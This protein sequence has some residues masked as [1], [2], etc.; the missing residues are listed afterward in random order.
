LGQAVSGV[1]DPA[2]RDSLVRPRGDALAA[3]L[4]IAQ[5]ISN[6]SQPM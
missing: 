6:Q 3:G 1:L 4:A 2:Y 5:N